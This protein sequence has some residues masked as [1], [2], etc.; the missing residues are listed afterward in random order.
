M[1]ALLEMTTFVFT[2]TNDKMCVIVL[3][4]TFAVLYQLLIYIGIIASKWALAFLV[5]TIPIDYPLSS[6]FPQMSEVL[7]F[8][9]SDHYMCSYITYDFS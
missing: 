3:F 4:V 6:V 9:L 2:V 5:W 1:Y 7:S 8:S